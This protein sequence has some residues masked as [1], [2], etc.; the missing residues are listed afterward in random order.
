MIAAGEEEGRLLGRIAALKG[1]GKRSSSRKAGQQTNVLLVGKPE[2]P[3]KCRTALSRGSDAGLGGEG[4][5]RM[6][7]QQLH[8]EVL[9]VEARGTHLTRTK[10]GTGPGNLPSPSTL[11]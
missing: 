2:G 8:S 1:G 4:W 10:N 11:R 9:S 5:E 7:I 3:V 6:T